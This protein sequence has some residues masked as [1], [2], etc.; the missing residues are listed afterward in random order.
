MNAAAEAYRGVIPDD[1]WHEPYMSRHE[2][3]G[4]VAA[5]VP[6]WGCETDGSM[7][8]IMGIQPVRDVDLIRHAYV[9]PRVQGHGVVSALLTHL[10]QLSRRRMLVGTWA[11]A[12]WAIRFYHYH[13]F[14]MVSTV[15]K[16]ISVTER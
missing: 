14:E 12:H 9:L 1:R 4:E 7:I 10:R 3:D 13:G 16:M 6:F 15:F 8:G 5:G 11:A 2:L